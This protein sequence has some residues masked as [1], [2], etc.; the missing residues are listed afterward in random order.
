MIKYLLITAGMVV[1]AACNNGKIN[2]PEYDSPV[3]GNIKISIDESFKPVMLEQLDM[4]KLSNPATIINASFKPEADCLR[5]F[6]TDTSVRMMV[7]T[8]PLTMHE[9]TTMK[10]EL[11]YRPRTGPIAMDAVTLVVNKNSNDTLFTLDD[12][13]GYLSGKIKTDRVFVFDGLNATSTVRF[14]QDSILKGETFDTTVVKATEDSKAVLEYVARTENAV[15]FVGF[16]WIGNPEIKEQVKMLDS[17][18][19]GYVRCDL[20][21]SMP[22]VQ[23][24]QENIINNR[25]P[26]VRALYYTVRENYMGLGT[27]FAS[28]LL[29]ER[30]Q[31][32]FKRYYL[33]SIMSFNTR[34]VEMSTE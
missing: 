5:D 9:E 31:L 25:Y 15:G 30:G 22:Y 34:N 17:V 24:R 16:S 20:C 26:L 4:Y 14:V 29:Y 32:I 27:G 10:N 7:T 2:A 19:L 18:K 28:F 8:R 13:R 11:G 6:L 1:M 23:P 12:L 21:D 3:N 33:G